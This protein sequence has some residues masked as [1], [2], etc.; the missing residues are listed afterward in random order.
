MMDLPRN[1]NQPESRS[2]ATKGLT[3]LPG[4]SRHAEASGP[5]LGEREVL[6][7]LVEELPDIAVLL[8]DA[9]GIIT[10]HSATME[11][12]LGYCRDDTVGHS[13]AEFILRGDIEGILNE[14]TKSERIDG[15][16]VTMKAK[17]GRKLQ[18]LLTAKVLKNREGRVAGVVGILRDVTREKDLE[19]KLRHE[20]NY[21]A[22]LAANSADAIIG[23]D[24]SGRIRSWNRGAQ[25]IFGYDQHEAIGRGLSLIVPDRRV[26]RRVLKDIRERIGE[27]GSLRSSEIPAVDRTGRNLYLNVTWTLMRD[28]TGTPIG[29]SAVIRDATERKRLQASELH[30]QR[31]AVVGRMTA[32]I[33]HEVKNPLASIRLNIEMLESELAQIAEREIS[34]EVGELIESVMKE[35]ERL[36]RITGEYLDYARIPKMRFHRQCLHETLKELQGFMRKE[37]E[38]RKIKFV[39]VFSESLPKIYF[40]KERVKEAILNLYKNSAE[41]M[42]HGGRITTVTAVSDDWAE[43]VISDTGLG[44]R[45]VDA[46]KLFEPFFST[47]SAGTGLGLPI[48]R[49]IIGAHG[50]SIEFHPKPGEGASFLLKLPLED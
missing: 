34:K 46:E 16:E 33:A 26:H 30:A 11:K 4:R 37:M 48:A 12:L 44:I 20:A 32:G 3:P 8:T 43:I 42:P 39:N 9:R 47:K 40:D 28:E 7:R 13:A 31:L 21:L 22:N 6:D 50:G 25:V 35:V 17:D 29:K 24:N 49:D 38:S 14:L 41:A 23:F 18:C 45:R 5:L 36:E 2:N 27:S 1:S 15:R 19:R 10:S